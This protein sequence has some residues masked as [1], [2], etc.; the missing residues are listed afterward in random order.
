MCK[1]VLK[2]LLAIRVGQKLRFRNLKNLCVRKCFP[3]APKEHELRRWATSEW[4]EY[5]AWL[6]YHAFLTEKDWHALRQQALAWRNPPLIS[7]ITPVY[8]TKE[9][10][11][12]ECIYSIMTQ[13]YPYWEM[14]LVD[15]G[16][17]DNQTIR[18]LKEL[19]SCDSRLKLEL[20][21]VNMGI[22][23]ATN[24]ALKMAQGEYVA[25]L[26]HDDRLSPDALYHVVEAIRRNSHLDILYS[27]CDMLSPRGL[28]F[29]HLFKTDWSPE[30]LFSFNYICHFMVYRRQLVETVRGMHAEFEG[31]QDYDLIL[32]AAELNPSIH[33]IPRVLYH[34]R[35][36]EQS[37]ALDHD[38]KRYVWEA[39]V[40]AL[41]KTLKRRGLKGEVYEISD[42]WRGN[43]RVRL[44][45]PSKNT[46]GVLSVDHWTQADDFAQSLSQKFKAA[47]D[48][49]YLIVLG[50]DIL[51]EDEHAFQELVSWFQIPEVGIVTG[52][53][54]DDQKRILHAGLVH[55][56][57]GIPLFIYEG[58]P[59]TTPSYM[60]ATSIVRNVSG[61]HPACFAI[62]R[63]LWDS[64]MG[65]KPD[66]SGPHAILD[67]ALRALNKG[68][69]IV[70]TPFARF[71]SEKGWWRMDDLPDSD[72]RYFSKQWA[73]WLSCGDPYYNRWLTIDRVDM[74]LNLDVPQSD[75]IEKPND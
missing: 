32:R 72:R 59:E 6:F 43:Y 11:L 65:L 44:R 49:E 70:Y 33:H 27:D 19:V 53:V 66:Y 35:Q 8:N 29:M 18:L 68:S 56:P 4:V 22:C 64:L 13:A 42:L 39:G 71:V 38:E 48:R 30:L 73:S 14:C 74:G 25:F 9:E 63:T 61:P 57:D 17:I 26:D 60:G 23:H 24:R 46:F 67:L 7:V 3:D 36:H 5:Q 12:Y 50:S 55:R 15:D 62:R 16:S 31:S 69:R 2:R 37:V 52:K 1:P 21:P 54:L 45:S 47:P 41:Q 58:F 10:H 28:R 20:S 40:R 51:P 75:R 34:W